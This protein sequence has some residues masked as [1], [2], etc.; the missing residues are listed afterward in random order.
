[1]RAFLRGLLLENL[2]LKLVA[3]ALSGMLFLY[4]QGERKRDALGGALVRLTLVPPRGK[5]L[6][7]EVA[8]KIMLQVRGARSDVE[9]LVTE[10]IPPLEVDLEGRAPGP[11]RFSPDLFRLPGRLSIESITPPEVDVS[12]DDFAQRTVPLRPSIAGQPASGYRVVSVAV[13]PREVE[14]RG[15]RTA[16]D[17]MQEV[18]L[19][20]TRIDGRTEDAMI[21]A[22]VRLK[23]KY[24]LARPDTAMLT[25][26]I[27]AE[28]VTQRFSGISLRLINPPPGLEV[29]P[30]PPVAQEV[31]LEGAANAI[32]RVEP[33][34][35]RAVIDLADIREPREAP[36]IKAARVEGLP[37]G[38]RALATT[39]GTFRIRVTRR[40]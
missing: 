16:L 6:T 14:V 24:L 3:L 28:T 34:G 33:Q 11:L 23:Q 22:R 7:T 13:E 18:V 20:E 27:V 17:R 37:A 15:P 29:E 26:R 39:P 1:M 2:G 8:E 32:K 36:Y 31:V 30:S 38:V 40:P 12:W 21:T 4:V 9:R 10:G 25:V 5:V 19:G 35:L